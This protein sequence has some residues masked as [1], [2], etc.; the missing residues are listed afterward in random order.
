MQYVIEILNLTVRTQWIK[1]WNSP[2]EEKQKLMLR[3]G[4]EYQNIK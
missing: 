2:N 1:F 3:P 4:I